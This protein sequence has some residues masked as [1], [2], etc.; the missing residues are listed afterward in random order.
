MISLLALT[1]PQEAKRCSDYRKQA[2][3]ILQKAVQRVCLATFL[4]V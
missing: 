1:R 3:N 4:F 2:E